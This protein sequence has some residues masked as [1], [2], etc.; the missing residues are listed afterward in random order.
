MLRSRLAVMLLAGLIAIPAAAG[1]KTVTAHAVT[2]VKYGSSDSK[3]P[4]KQVVVLFLENHSFDSLLGF[5]CDIHRTRCPVGGMPKSVTLSDG[6]VVKP[7]DDPDVTPEVNHSITSQLNAMNIQ[8][9]VPQMN[10][11]QR[12]VAGGCD[13]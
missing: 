5:W 3:I 13:V 7:T 11:W 4:I 9:G 10:G 8:N 2:R 6:S 1:A 12:I